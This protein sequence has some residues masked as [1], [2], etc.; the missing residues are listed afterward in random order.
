MIAIDTVVFSNPHTA[1]PSPPPPLLMYGYVKLKVNAWQWRLQFVFINDKKKVMRV[2]DS[3]C[4]KHPKTIK[5]M[6]HELFLD[7]VDTD[8]SLRDT[9]S[10]TVHVFRA[11]NPEVC[12]MYL[13]HI[14][15]IKQGIDPSTFMGTTRRIRFNLRISTLPFVILRALHNAETSESDERSRF[16]SIEDNVRQEILLEL[17]DCI[18][19]T[20][21][22]EGKMQLVEMGFDGTLASDALVH[23]S[24]NVPAAVEVL[25]LRAETGVVAV[26]GLNVKLL[27]LLRMGYR[28][29]ES[30]KSLQKNHGD[31]QAAERELK[32][33]VQNTEVQQRQYST[34]SVSLPAVQTQMQT[35]QTHPA[36][37]SPN[38]AIKT[39]SRLAALDQEA[40][41]ID[42]R[43]HVHGSKGG[44]SPASFLALHENLAPHVLFQEQVEMTEKVDL[45]AL[46][47]AA[48]SE[49][50]QLAPR[51]RGGGG[52]GGGVADVAVVALDIEDVGGLELFVEGGEPALGDSGLLTRVK[53]EKKEELLLASPRR[54][55][56]E[57]EGVVAA[58]GAGAE[59]AVPAASPVDAK[60]E[61]EARQHPD[62]EDGE[63]VPAVSEVTETTPEVTETTPEVTE[64]A[65]EAEIAPEAETAPEVTE[66]APEVAEIAPEVTETAPEVTEIAPEVTETTP[67]VTETAP[68]AEITPEAETAPEVTETAPEVTEI[69][70]EVTETA[71]EVTEI[72]PEVTETAPEAEIAPEVTETA[73]EV[74]ETA[75]E[76][77]IAPEVTET[78]P[79]VTETAP[80]A[81]I[82]PEVTETAPEVTETAP[83]AEIAPEAETAPEVTETTPEVTETAPEAEIAPEAETAPEPETTPAETAQCT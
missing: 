51:E 8:F 57:E 25:T 2:S 9:K 52:G 30:E 23:T 15:M 26:A 45:E 39:I 53:L 65:P 61:V 47:F 33:G 13:A 12:G 3:P 20:A 62:A 77:E 75:P 40:L 16:A 50:T 78:A 48:D 59:E 28:G 72:A 70:P 7:K 42:D 80:E 6:H 71:P 58:C 81:E 60:E 27:K 68:E 22:A 24:G 46:D 55:V 63:T 36:P 29:R 31:L 41:L 73:P 56:E 18:Y 34:T 66:T 35:I 69:A 14:K 11:S 76:A 37:L 38:P 19:L 79:E 32:G 1:P 83:E 4:A 49:V 44:V 21:R 82:A 67:E 43:E 17:S 74:T 54:V 5:L 10:K 64:T